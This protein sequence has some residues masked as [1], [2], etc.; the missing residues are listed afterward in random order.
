[1]VAEIQLKKRCGSGDECAENP[2]NIHG[3][4]DTASLLVAG[5]EA[6]KLFRVQRVI[7]DSKLR[8][9]LCLTRFKNLPSI[10]CPLFIS[11]DVSENVKEFWELSFR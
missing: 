8:E 6:N 9:E 2:N 1:M 3:F 5:E 11:V 7:N 10:L 4:V